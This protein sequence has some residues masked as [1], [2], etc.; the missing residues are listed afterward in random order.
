MGLFS[1]L[2]KNEKSAFSKYDSNANKYKIDTLEHIESIPVPTK[3]FD[4]TCDFTKSIEYVLQ[5]KATEFKKN[6]N[7]EMAIACLRKSNEIMPFAEINYTKK[8]YMRL[9]EFLKQVGKFEEARKEENKIN[10]IFGTNDSTTTILEKAKETS[11]ITNIDENKFIVVPRDGI[12]CS[13][14]AKYHDRI[15]SVDGKDNRFPNLSIFENYITN[16]KCKC[17]LPTFPFIYGISIFRGEGADNP[18]GYSNRPFEDDRTDE[19]KRI[20]DDKL[21]KEMQEEKDR[22]DYDW[23]RENISELAPKS[24]GGYR[25]MKNKNSVNYQKIVSAA[26]DKGYII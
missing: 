7:M 14:C 25:N 18:I 1:N 23:I 20:Y 5:R 11:S 2:F 19:E 21:F 13:N 24:F 12:V 10:E 9:P 22:R 8:E 4:Y 3:K 16:K 17:T 6:G 15:Y 26:K